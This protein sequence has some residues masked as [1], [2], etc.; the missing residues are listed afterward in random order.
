MVPFDTA[1]ESLGV[2][3]QVFVLPVASGYPSPKVV[4]LV[5]RK[6]RG[7]AYLFESSCAR[8]DVLADLFAQLDGHGVSRLDGVLVTH[9]HGDHAGSAGIVAARGYPD[10]ERAPIHLHSASYRFLTHPE[11]AFL[12]ETYELFLTRAHWGLLSFNGLSNQE[13]V[14]HELRKQF[15]GYFARTP[16]TALRFVDQAQIPDGIWALF[17][18]GH[19]NDCVLY[20]DEELGIA[21]PG[22]TII[23]TGA[24][25]KPETHGYV[26]P[27]FTVAGQ[28]YSMAYERY[29]QT[30][31]VLR[32]FFETHLVRAVLP[33]HGKF[34]IT[35][36]L[37]W[38]SF[39]EGYF[40]GIYRALLQD[41]LSDGARRTTPFLACDL[42]RFIPS[43][44]A[45]PISTPS[46]TFGMLC[47]LV[48]EGYFSMDEHPHTRKISFSVESMPPED[49]VSKSLAREPGPLPLFMHSQRAS[50]ARVASVPPPH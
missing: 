11:A 45:H 7:N 9:C 5:L 22:D 4:N 42:N 6:R 34:A 16:K 23:C 40:K 35:E 25:E 27:I 14:D 41:F 19:S 31:R 1:L 29:I 13:M 36:P 18:P 49:W 32:R 2:A 24:V 44:G 50:S 47:A 38:V 46:H 37:E 15:S 21:V 12:N 33:P 17:T 8:E 43:A 26:I 10:G 48:D 20:Y 28:S 3:E 30:I 39:A